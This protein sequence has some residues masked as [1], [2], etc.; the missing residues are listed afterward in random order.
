MNPTSRYTVG[1]RFGLIAGLLYIVLLFIRYNFFN[2]SPVG[3]GFFAIIT[4]I[5]ILLVYLITGMYRK[6]EL[7]GYGELKEIFQ[8][9]FITILITE[10]SYILFNFIFLKY[11]NPSF[12]INFKTVSLAF[13]QQQKLP[14]EQIEQAMKGLK[15]IDKATN[16]GGLVSGFG[17]SVVIDCIFGF[18]F[19]FILRK[20]KPVVQGIA[21]DQKL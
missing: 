8:S 11:V 18:I 7:G 13:Y 16:L 20:K 10:F 6:K 21:E 12:W 14:P 9:I 2:K 3:F 1:L 5:I 17:Y 4:Y 15:D 19:A